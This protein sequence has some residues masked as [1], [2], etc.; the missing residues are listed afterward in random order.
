MTMFALATIALLVFAYWWLFSAAEKQRRANEASHSKVESEPSLPH[1]RRASLSHGRGNAVESTLPLPQADS[2]QPLNAVEVASHGPVERTHTITIHIDAEEVMAGAREI[3][4]KRMR[5]S[6]KS[7]GP[8]PIKNI[9]YNQER[10]LGDAS[11]GK[12]IIASSRDESY[13]NAPDDFANHQSRTVNSLVKHG[14]LVA[15]GTGTF[16]CTDLGLRAYESLPTK[17]S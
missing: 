10:C 8:M 11:L 14:F 16:I 9:T 17:F 5:W 2:R 1:E 7:D 13:S 6:G 3:N 12:R 15:N 4:K